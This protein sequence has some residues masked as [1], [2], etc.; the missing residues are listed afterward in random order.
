MTTPTLQTAPAPATPSKPAAAPADGKGR[1]RRP[2]IPAK[3]R[4]DIPADEMQ[5]NI[6]PEKEKADLRRKREERSAQQKAVDEIVY[7][8]FE[9]NVARR[10]D[11]GTIADW[12]DLFVYDW[13]I[14]LTHEE[15]AMFLI[16]KGCRLYNRKP[17]WG[18]RVEIKASATHDVPGEEGDV[19]CH[20]NGKA[21][22]HI[23]FSVVR[24]PKRTEK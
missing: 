8:V 20:L 6:L 17:I 23:P 19:P 7:N 15:T 18:E 2:G 4:A 3:I 11:N 14:T 1:G 5:L 22:V 24:R 21:H 12:A 16:N 13:P 10:I 9:E